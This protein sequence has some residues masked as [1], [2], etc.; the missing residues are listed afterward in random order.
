MK[1]LLA[2]VVVLTA[3]A[4]FPSGAAAQLEFIT[5]LYKDVHS[6]TFYGQS[7]NINTGGVEGNTEC[8][9]F[10]EDVACGAGTEV[11]IDVT[12]R[13]AAHL[14]LGLGASYMR[15]FSYNRGAKLFMAVRS[16]PTLSLYATHMF[17]RTPLGVY[18]GASFGLADLLNAQAYDVDNREY[19]VS[20]T[21]FE[22]GGT[23]GAYVQL[24]ALGPV[25]V[26]AEYSYRSRQFA[27]INYTLSTGRDTV[28]TTF[29][30][31]L[32]LSGSYISA[33][34]QFDLKA[35]EPGTPFYAGVWALARVDALELPALVAAQGIDS[36][37]NARTEVLSGLFILDPTSDP[38]ADPRYL[39]QLQ[40]R[41]STVNA[42]GQVQTVDS[43]AIRSESGRYTITEDPQVLVL[44]PEVADALDGGRVPMRDGARQVVRLDEEI[45]IRSLGGTYGL[46]FSRTKAQNRFGD[47]DGS[48]P[49]VPLPAPR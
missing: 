8:L 26:F 23:L 43:T 46:V 47:P 19:S 33:G 29:P 15:G 25:G 42:A 27:S 14:E 24:R 35:D 30:Q 12:A 32:D 11:L 48:G 34:V 16:F 28:P 45:R 2:L 39:L 13:G 7:G 17:E 20:A 18:G 9:F 41:Y 3:G 1:R 21:T 49:A 5:G 6:V 37:R 38:K 4:F 22:T 40:V 44:I 10:Q 31:S 36:N